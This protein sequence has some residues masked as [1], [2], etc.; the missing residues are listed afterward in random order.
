MHLVGTS[1]WIAAEAKR[2]SLLRRFPSTIIPNG[3][4]TADFSPRDKAVAREKL[5]VPP[6]AKVVLFVAE[7]SAIKRKGFDYLSAA[8]EKMKARSDLFLLSVGSGKPNVP[9]LPQLHL[10]RISDDRKLSEIYS[11]ADVF[12]IPSLQES[13]GQTVTESLACGTPVVGFN[14][15]GI[16][17]MVRPGITGYLAPVEMPTNLHWQ[18][19]RYWMTLRLLPK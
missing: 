4:D 11:A 19:P 16:P 17:D 5:G 9:D 12:V 1:R 15:G 14:T 10:G 7:S 8:L 2:S 18:S 13:F 6:D 3:L